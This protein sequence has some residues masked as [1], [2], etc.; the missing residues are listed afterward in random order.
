[1]KDEI[2]GRYKELNF[3][4]K[5]K[6]NLLEFF[7]II[8]HISFFLFCSGLIVRVRSEIAIVL[9]PFITQESLL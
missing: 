8:K 2:L 4:L 6:K 7:L 9:G 5:K 1:M 3:S